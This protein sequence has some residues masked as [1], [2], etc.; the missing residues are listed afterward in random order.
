V[1]RSGESTPGETIYGREEIAATVRR[2]AGELKVR[3]A[4]EEPTFLVLLKGGARF[5][6][7]LIEAWAG[8]CDYDFIGV[9]SY[10][11][12]TESTGVL[13][14]YLYPPARELID[15]RTVVLVDDI[16]DSGKTLAEVTARLEQEFTLRRL[17]G[18]ALILRAGAG[19]EPE[20]W[21]FRHRDHRFL[22]GYG[23]GAG[24]RFRWLEGI[25][26]LQ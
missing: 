26:A 14:Y 23:L 21:G 16:C 11:R 12:S 6:C 24:E 13:E 22:V 15:N 19:Y 3:L 9:S 1:T 18:C 5:G 20:L 17:I 2:L 25:A 10:G 8:P 4:G 7:A